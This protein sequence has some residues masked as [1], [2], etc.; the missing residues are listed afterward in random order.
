MEEQ[1]HHHMSHGSILTSVSV[2][3]LDF[4]SLTCCNHGAPNSI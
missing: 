3:Q 2:Q 1:E 4:L